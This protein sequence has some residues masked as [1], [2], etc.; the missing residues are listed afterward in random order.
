MEERD[1]DGKTDTLLERENRDVLFDSGGFDSSADAGGESPW[2]SLLVASHDAGGLG[3]TARLA[4]WPHNLGISHALGSDLSGGGDV[5]A[6]HP[7]KGATA[8]GLDE[9]QSRSLEGA[10]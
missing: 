8:D 2:L 6:P 3:L 5:L 4:E 1:H 9:S 7:A 10:G